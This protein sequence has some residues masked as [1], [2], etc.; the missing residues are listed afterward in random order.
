MGADEGEVAELR[1]ALGHAR[2]K[3][4]LYGDG[5]PGTISRSF[6]RIPRKVAD[7]LE[8]LLWVDTDGKVL[9]ANRTMGALLAADG[10]E[11]L[12]PAALR[13]R[14]LADLDVL[15]YAPGILGV[16]L[17]EAR[18]QLMPVQHEVRLGDPAGGE[19]HMVFHAEV[20]ARGGH[21]RVQ[22][23]S[24]QRRIETFFSRYVGGEVLELMKERAEED[25]F[26]TTRCTMTV[27]FADLRGFTRASSTL[28]PE[29]VCE[30]I[31]EFLAAMIDVVDEHRA[32]VDKI[33]GDEVMVLCG[34]PVPAADHAAQALAVGIGMVKAQ[35]RLVETWRRRNLR[36]LADLQ[37]GVGINTGEMVVG[38][39]G[40]RSRTQYTVLGSAVN[41]GARL[42]SHAEG[43]QILMSRDS[44]EAVRAVIQEQPDFFQPRLEGFREHAPV[45]AKGFP[46]PI[47]VVAYA[48]APEGG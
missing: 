24:A 8:P 1:Q 44:F 22:D 4:R 43:G 32:T 30:F 20:S 9:E 25:F 3:L 28:A 47:P 17:T 19:R 2:A 14:P 39:I 10:Q 12:E 33:V 7:G 15:E 29:Q 27:L 45:D 5:S 48:P 35:A 11:A 41:L 37:V 46:E 42:C 31:N 34:A 18:E 36:E 21:V 6:V 16:L 23:V 13:G 38:N 26:R 40:S